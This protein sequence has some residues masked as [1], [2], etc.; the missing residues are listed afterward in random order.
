MI[1]LDVM[2]G[3]Y[4]P[5]QIIQGAIAAA[6]KGLSIQLFGDQIQIMRWLDQSY[7]KWEKLPLQLIH[8]SDIVAMDDEPTAALRKE[9]S[10]L[11]Q[12]IAAVK[13]GKAKA[14]VSAG[15]TGACLVGGMMILGKVPGVLRAAIG[16][17]LPTK[18]GTVFCIDLGANVDCKIE[19]LK[20]FALM[21]DVYVR[22]KKKIINPRIGLL[23]NGAER[24]KGTRT[25]IETH[26]HFA[27]MPINFIGNCE[28]DAILSDSADVVVCDGFTGNILLK[29]CE[30]M[31]RTIPYW[32]GKECQKSVFYKLFGA[33]FPR[34]IRNVKKT[35]QAQKGGALLLGVQKPII[36]AHGSSDAVAIE[37]ALLFAHE[38]IKT[39]FVTQFNES[40]EVMLKQ[41]MYIA[42]P[43]VQPQKIF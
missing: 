33:F 21:G 12:A 29:T 2:G 40:L 16:E 34:I 9:K 20:Q 22:L 6:K 15:N 25:I 30:A 13:S 23:S 24:G 37:N 4:A 5:A 26:E 28:P 8:C 32:I 3:D 41:S 42:Q 17:F 19:H 10:S 27:Q 31:A 38:L 36:I 7:P 14:I 1:A 18:S 39:G 35:V 11:M 43:D